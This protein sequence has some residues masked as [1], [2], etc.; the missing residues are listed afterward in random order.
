M[1]TK[2]IS[3]AK[4]LYELRSRSIEYPSE[5][6]SKDDGTKIKI[7]PILQ[8]F[9]RELKHSQNARGLKYYQYKF[10]DLMKHNFHCVLP[11]QA[12][13]LMNITQWKE[14]WNILIKKSI[15]TWQILVEFLVRK[16]QDM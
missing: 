9:Y 10:A 5:K 8:Q 3:P 11:L 13:V 2:S 14:S 15:K 1:K 4:S 12:T 16:R 6:N 7:S